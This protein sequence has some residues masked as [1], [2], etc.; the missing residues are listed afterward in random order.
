MENGD[1]KKG[2]EYYNKAASNKD[3]MMLTPTF[4]L[5]AGL[6]YESQNQ[7]EEAKK[8]YLRIRDEYPTSDQARDIDRYL[9]RL[10]T[11]N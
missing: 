9:A 10:G 6:A 3:D 4:L 11:L 7:P 2:I 5:R 1:A 8:V